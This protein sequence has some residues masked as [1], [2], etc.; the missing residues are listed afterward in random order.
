MQREK[1]KTEKTTER[2][3]DSWIM[4]KRRVKL[5]RT[6]QAHF[7]S[8][9]TVLRPR[10]LLRLLRFYRLSSTLTDLF[11]F[12]S[13]SRFQLLQAHIYPFVGCC[14]LYI[15]FHS[16]RLNN[17]HSRDYTQATGWL[18]DL[19]LILDLILDLDLVISFSSTAW[20]PTLGAQPSI[21][22]LACYIL[23]LFWAIF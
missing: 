15:H 9:A 8:R 13:G 19:I 10:Q 11:F 2:D 17:G 4:T 22:A 18:L 12:N 21:V 14:I 7:G 23:I 3:R 16:S 6:R 20:L 1:E 5:F